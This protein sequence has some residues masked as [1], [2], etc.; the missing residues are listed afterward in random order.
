[1]TAAERAADNETLTNR[2][3][4]VEERAANMRKQ[5]EKEHR[6]ELER[7]ARRV[8]RQ[9]EEIIKDQERLARFDAA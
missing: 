7:H 8:Q 5:I 2:L 4:A 9:R 6:S 3:A 1:M